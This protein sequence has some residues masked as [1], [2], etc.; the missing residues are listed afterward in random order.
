MCHL[1]CHYEYCTWAQTEVRVHMNMESS[2]ATAA[3]SSMFFRSFQPT[4]IEI[5]FPKDK[6]ITTEFCEWHEITS[7]KPILRKSVLS[8]CRKCHVERK[9]WSRS[10]TLRGRK[11]FLAEPCRL[12]SER[13]KVRLLVTICHHEKLA[14]FEPGFQQEWQMSAADFL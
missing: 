11:K 7:M 6:H 4:V 8:V 2:W 9:E 10:S 3:S 14:S 12:N 1:S 5:M 13:K